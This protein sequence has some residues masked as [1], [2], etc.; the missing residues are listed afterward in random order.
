MFIHDDK[1]SSMRFVPYYRPK[2]APDRIKDDPRPADDGAC[3]TPIFYEEQRIKPDIFLN[4]D[5]DP[6]WHELIQADDTDTITTDERLR[7][8]IKERSRELALKICEQCPELVREACLEEALKMDVANQQ[9]KEASSDQPPEE[10][11]SYPLAVGI[12]AG[13]TTGERAESYLKS[14]K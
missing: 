11:L 13:L 12:R 10:G 5:D 14:A 6:L 3:V 9:A 2:Y 1:F 4:G 7:Y 8:D